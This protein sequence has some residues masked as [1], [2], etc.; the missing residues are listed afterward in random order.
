MRMQNWLVVA[1]VAA[2]LCMGVSNSMAQQ[3]N[4]GQ[5]GGRRGNRN[6]DPAQMQQ[7]MLERYKEVLEVTKDDEW[8]VL[9]PLV[10]KVM[11]ARRDTFGGMGRGMFGGRRGGG[12]NPDQGGGGGVRP[13]GFGQ[14][15]P[16]AEALQKAIEA[17]ASTAE[18]KAAL[19]RFVEARKAKAEQLK[20][21]QEELRKVLTVRQ[22]AIAH[23]NG[24]LSTQ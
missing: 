21:A 5:G 16:E 17:K 13:G 10:Q 3:D 20:A 15:S 12:A 8:N 19:G 6:M 18:I 11:A 14:P 4:A 23:L 1:G 9:Q 22:E 24:L 7:R 2:A